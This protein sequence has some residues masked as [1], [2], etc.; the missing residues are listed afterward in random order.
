LA[1]Y[2]QLLIDNL[3]L[4]ERLVRFVSRRHHLSTSDGEEF[5]GVVRLRLVEDDFAILRKFEHR[6]TLATY[7]TVVIERLCQDFIVAR[8]GKW[9]PSAAARRLGP[10]AIL[11]EQLVVRDGVTFE[12]A[13]GTLQTNHGITQTY[14]QLREMYIALPQRTRWTAAFRTADQPADPDAFAAQPD[15]ERDVERISAALSDAVA[16]LT[17]EEQ[18]ILKLRFEEN[19]TVSEISA[20]VHIDSR[21]LYRRLHAVIRALRTSLE[22][23]GV[24]EGDIRRVVGHPT[25]LLRS[26]LGEAM[27]E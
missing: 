3:E 15:D 17:G 21:I 26:V 19:R 20:I 8:W 9:R 24:R 12:E 25:M 1:H 11:L 13:V 5:A 6:S 14:Q 10:V 18:R 2:R 16:R 22:A 7:L 23:Q 4:I 27:R